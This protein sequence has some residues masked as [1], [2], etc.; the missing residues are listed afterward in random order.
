MSAQTI[1]DN[2]ICI[3][4]CKLLRQEIRHETLGKKF[5]DLVV[6]VWN[7]TCWSVNH[8][9]FAVSKKAPQFKN[10]SK[11]ILLKFRYS[12]K[13]N[14][15]GLFFVYVAISPKCLSVFIL[16]HNN[17]RS[18]WRMKIYIFMKLNSIPLVLRLKRRKTTNNVV[19]ILHTEKMFWGSTRC[20][21]SDIQTFLMWCDIELPD[22]S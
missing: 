2:H 12:Q 20:P 16:C 10:R 11:A 3:Q 5:L 7:H 4:K 14:K 15:T 18:E 22:A 17:M 19:F 6:I 8:S 21:L 1:T 9:N 13:L